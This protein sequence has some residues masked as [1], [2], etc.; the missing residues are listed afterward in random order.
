MVD[1]EEGMK[2]KA[3]ALT[4][5]YPA[6]LLTHELRRRGRRLLMRRYRAR[7]P[8][9]GVKAAAFSAKKRSTEV[10]GAPVTRSMS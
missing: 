3:F 9:V 5:P 8:P 10:A 4:V 6:N 7:L 2:P 1:G